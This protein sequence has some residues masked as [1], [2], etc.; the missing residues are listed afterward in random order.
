MSIAAARVSSDKI[1]I[2]NGRSATTTP[3]PQHRLSACSLNERHAAKLNNYWTLPRP[4]PPLPH[5]MLTATT[6]NHHETPGCPVRSELYAMRSSYST[7]PARRSVRRQ[8]SQSAHSAYLSRHDEDGRYSG[9]P[10]WRDDQD[11][12]LDIYA[13]L[14]PRRCPSP[15]S[16]PVVIRGPRPSSSSTHQAANTVDSGRRSRHAV[17]TATDNRQL[18]DGCTM[19]SSFRRRPEI[20]DHRRPDSGPSSCTP[21]VPTSPGH[22]AD[23][24]QLL[25]WSTTLNASGTTTM[26]LPPRR[27]AVLDRVSADTNRLDP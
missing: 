18:N 9:R 6:V 22:T 5:R 16:K 2:R 25:S 17:S 20:S 14:T 21:V 24:N 8:P 1:K 13:T 26:P 3:F 15:L 23:R 12:Q 27:R 19:T 7:S 4:P 10:T 11:R